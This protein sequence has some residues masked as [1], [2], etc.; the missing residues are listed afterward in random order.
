M[1]PPIHAKHESAQATDNITSRPI[2]FID[3]FP[4]QAPIHMPTCNKANSMLDQ[5]TNVGY[6]TGPRSKHVHYGICPKNT[7]YTHCQECGREMSSAGQGAPV[8]PSQAP[9]GLR[10]GSPGMP[11]RRP[12]SVRIDSEDQRMQRLA[13]EKERQ[14]AE[15]AV[16]PQVDAEI[17]AGNAT[18]P[19]AT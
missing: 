1:L 14:K 16:K 5:V 2:I 4:N 18:S 10:H 19:A 11:N 7:C 9:A 13:G 12:T 6:T 15:T 17:E 8:P 3:T